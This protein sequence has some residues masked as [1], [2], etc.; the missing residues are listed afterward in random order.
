MVKESASGFANEA[1]GPI[2]MYAERKPEDLNAP[3]ILIIANVTPVRFTAKAI[4]TRSQHLLWNSTTG[5]GDQLATLF[6]V[7]L[8]GFEP[9]FD[10][11]TGVLNPGLREWLLLS[12]DKSRTPQLSLIDPQ[13]DV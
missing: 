9:S 11:L 7:Y 3:S 8:Q 13:P 10:C 1:K 5:K 6:E 12:P 2:F 4:R